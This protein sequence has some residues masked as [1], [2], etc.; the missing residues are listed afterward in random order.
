MSLPSADALRAAMGA[1]WPAAEEKPVGPFLLRR[2]QGGGQRVIAATVAPGATG[3]AEALPRAEAQ[4]QSWGQTR[5][6]QGHPADAGARCAARCGGL[7][8]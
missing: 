8:D 2:S 4:M 7:C 5:I 3:L 1:T 6:F